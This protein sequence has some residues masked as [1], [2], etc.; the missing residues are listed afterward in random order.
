MMATRP[1]VGGTVESH[2]RPMTTAKMMTE[3][4]DFGSRMKAE[5][6]TERAM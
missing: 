1:L 2:K 3:A 5:T 4:G 6:A